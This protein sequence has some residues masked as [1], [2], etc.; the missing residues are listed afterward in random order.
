[1]YS[2]KKKMENRKAKAKN[3]YHATKEKLQERW[4]EY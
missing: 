1:M 4:Q 2:Q 3:Y